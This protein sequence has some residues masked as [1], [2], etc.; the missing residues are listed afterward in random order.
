MS[1]VNKIILEYLPVLKEMKMLFTTF[2]GWLLTRQNGERRCT[3]QQSLLLYYK[4]EGGQQFG[5]QHVGTTNNK[6]LLLKYIMLFSSNS[7]K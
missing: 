4:S 3:R 5:V 2:V 6:S 1:Y 7:F